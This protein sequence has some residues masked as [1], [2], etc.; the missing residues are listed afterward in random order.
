MKRVREILKRGRR[1]NIRRVLEERAPVLRGWA[2]YFNL[3]DVKRPLETLD[4]WV[5][6]PQRSALSQCRL[7]DRSWPK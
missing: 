7:K 1:R 6:P 5:R 2:S 4:G 3:V